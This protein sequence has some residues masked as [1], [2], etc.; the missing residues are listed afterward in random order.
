M[1]ASPEPAA[2]PRQLQM[3]ADLAELGMEL[4]REVQHLAKSRLVEARVSGWDGNLPKDPAA[5]FV[6]IAQTVRR[7]IAL[8]V[9]LRQ[10][11]PALAG[12]CF[13]A[14]PQPR[15]LS[16][17][18]AT[19]E[20]HPQPP[21]PPDA[22]RADAADPSDALDRPL[23]LGSILAAHVRDDLRG[24]LEGGERLIDRPAN[25]TGLLIGGLCRDLGLDPARLAWKG[26]R[27]VVE[28][29]PA[30]PSGAEEI[31]LRAWRPAPEATLFEPGP[32]PS[33]RTGETSDARL[34]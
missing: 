23:S 27:W 2:D 34:E 9:A 11:G 10:G 21:L 28:A 29:D 19:W 3:L 32:S 12:G 24:D 6:K 25:W 15:T 26:E 31:P 20:S 14:P 16:P 7:T 22:F 5:P 30:A 13:D 33:P 17:L 1:T 8:H 4:A 18:P